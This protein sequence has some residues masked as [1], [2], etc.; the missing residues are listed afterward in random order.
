MK[1]MNLNFGA[2]SSTLI[3]AKHSKKFCSKPIN[4]LK[5]TRFSQRIAEKKNIAKKNQEINFDGIICGSFV[6]EFEEIFNI[7]KLEEELYLI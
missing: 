6:A 3:P 5:Q 1:K 7:K 2:K 4:Q